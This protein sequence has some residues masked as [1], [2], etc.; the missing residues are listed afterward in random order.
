L[1]STRYFFL[2]VLV[3]FSL[4]LIVNSCKKDPYKLGIDLLP[5]SDT[6]N[7]CQTDTASILAWSVLQDSIRSDKMTVLMMGSLMDQV[8]GVTTVSFYTQFSLSN[9]A[10][11]FGTSP[12]LDSLVLLLDYTSV[13]GDTNTLQN[14]KVFEMAEDIYYDSAYY[15][16]QTK[17]TYDIMLANHSFKPGPK[18]SV[19]V[20]GYKVRPHLRINLSNMT[21]YLGNK[22]LDAPASA[23]VNSKSFIKFMKGLYLQTSQVYNSGA[24]LSF[25]PRGIFTKMVVY[26]HNEENDSLHFDF[27]I[28]SSCAN[29][30]HA[31]HNGYQEANYDLKRQVLYHDSLLG[32]QQVYLQ[33]LAGIRT[34]IRIPYITDFNNLGKIA[35]NDA[36]L[37][38]KLADPDTAD[39]PPPPSLN[40]LRVDST[41]KIAFLLDDDEGTA[42]FGGTY[43]SKS[44][45]Y[46][47]R[48]T[49][50]LQQILLGKT[51]NYDLYLQV[52]SPIKN[53]LV[54]NRFIATGTNPEPSSL[55]PNR[56]KLKIIYTKL[57]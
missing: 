50:H 51:K 34:R 53:V 42:Y 15:T 14:V 48:I 16:N 20:M 19:T 37:S 32:R 21:H 11:S 4:L 17:Q 12:V 22:L 25:N 43:S 13:Y 5:P 30:N 10:P 18:D 36:I 2:P 39:Y 47:F 29:F 6:L 52:N 24:M 9:D 38:F 27:P 45:M 1:K 56:V 7:V 26:F 35:L 55:T 28:A 44:G 31:D 3:L 54:P 33:G 40:L 41:G 46:E 23:M 8:F 57:Y 49:R